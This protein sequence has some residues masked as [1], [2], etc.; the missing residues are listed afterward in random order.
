MYVF[1]GPSVSP[2]NKTEPDI[3]KTSITNQHTYTFKR[4]QALYYECM[5]S[6]QELYASKLKAAL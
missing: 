1:V 2:S 3:P 6:V 5:L 4:G